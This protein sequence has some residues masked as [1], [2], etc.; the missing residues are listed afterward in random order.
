[1]NYDVVIVGNGVLGCTTAF[2]LSLAAP[3]LRIALVGPRSRKG[4][5]SLAAGAMLNLFAEL[6]ADALANPHYKFK[7]DLGRRA[8]DLWADHVGLLNEYAGADDQV[9]IRLGTFIVNNTRSDAFDDFSFEAVVEALTSYREPFEYV[10]PK[11]IDG[12]APSPT[13]RALRAI[14]L[15]EEGYIPSKRLFRAIDAAVAQRTS[16]VRIDADVTTLKAR[17]RAHELE[18]STGDRLAAEKV[19]LANGAAA[20]QLIDQVP[21]LKPR[22][23]RLFYGVGCGL[24]L[25]PPVNLQKVVRTNNRGLACGLHTVPDVEAG[26]CYVG[27]S[28]FIS[29]NPEYNVR[30]SS[31]QNLLRAAMQEINVS[32]YKAQLEEVRVGHRPTSADLFPLIGPT[33]IDGL[34]I[35]S[36]TKRDG[37]YMSPVYAREICDSLLSGALCFGGLFAPERPLIT[38]MTRDEGIKKAVAHLWSGAYQHELQL[39]H[40][41]WEAHVDAMLERRV[42]DAYEQAGNPDYGIPPELLDMYRY[43]HITPTLKEVTGVRGQGAAWN[44]EPVP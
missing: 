35:L 16:I 7:F 15:A 24:V 42:L 10:D 17:P 33:S 28:N 27:A 3:D 6:E 11:T 1:M 4:A 26:T 14:Y 38:T 29:Q 23:P 40:A 37:L 21:Q 34:F 20:Q 30:V 44:L 18:L 31:I 36:G 19:L 9:E 41:G 32:W 22:M 13:C 39:P 8:K 25:R 5:A 12:Y 43:R 2:H